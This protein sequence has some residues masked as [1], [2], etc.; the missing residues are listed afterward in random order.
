MIISIKNLQTKHKDSWNLLNIPIEFI[1]NPFITKYVI[2]MVIKIH[3]QI[4]TIHNQTNTIR[5][6]KFNCIFKVTLL[7]INLFKIL[8]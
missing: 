5:E 6:N 8:I 4:N 7:V 1:I 3:N 2:T